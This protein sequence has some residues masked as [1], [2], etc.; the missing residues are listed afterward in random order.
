MKFGNKQKNDCY[1]KHDQ[2][3]NFLGWNLVCFDWKL[4]KICSQL[5]LYRKQLRLCA[6]RVT[7]NQIWTND[8]LVYG[9][10]HH[11]ASLSLKPQPFRGQGDPTIARQPHG[12]HN[13]LIPSIRWR[14]KSI[15]TSESFHNT[16][17][18]STVCSDLHQK[19]TRKDRRTDAFWSGLIGNQWITPTKGE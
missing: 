2:P 9:C 12:K 7:N 1:T 13:T 10:M 18:C 16:T 8:C 17:G 19:K 4:T 15:K 3:C 14:H 5:T 6:E 11:S